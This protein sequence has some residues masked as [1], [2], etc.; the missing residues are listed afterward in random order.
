MFGM[1]PAWFA[2]LGVLLV[3][4]LLGREAVCWYW[5]LNTLLSELER[6]TAELMAIRGLLKKLVMQGELRAAPTAGEAGR[7]AVVA[8]LDPQ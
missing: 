3:V 4:F 1:D 2:G 7:A 6:Q 5:K 8:P